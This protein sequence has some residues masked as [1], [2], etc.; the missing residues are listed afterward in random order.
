MQYI[1]GNVL[2]STLMKLFFSSSEFEFLNFSPVIFSGES[3]N[4][5]SYL[6]LILKLSQN[7]IHHLRGIL[8]YLY[9]TK[10]HI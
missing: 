5:E 9:E 8:E 6:L 4:F 10:I 2:H 1:T 7:A 3:E